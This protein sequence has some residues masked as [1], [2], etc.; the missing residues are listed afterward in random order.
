MGLGQ[1]RFPNGVHAIDRRVTHKRVR[2]AQRLILNASSSRGKLF[3]TMNSYARRASQVRGNGKVFLYDGS[4]VLKS[5]WLN[6]R[7][8]M[9]FHGLPKGRHNLKLSFPD[10]QL[11]CRG[12]GHPLGHR[13]LTARRPAAAW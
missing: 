9:T 12:E 2:W 1:Y 10:E 8:V 13:P 6:G 4:R 7:R 3:V 11:L 5:F